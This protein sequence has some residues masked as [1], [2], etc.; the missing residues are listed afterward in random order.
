MWLSWLEFYFSF[1]R[2]FGICDKLIDHCNCFCNCFSLSDRLGWVREQPNNDTKITTTGGLCELLRTPCLSD[3]NNPSVVAQLTF[4]RKRRIGLD[5]TEE[6]KTKSR[7]GRTF[8]SLLFIYILIHTHTHFV[9]KVRTCGLECSL[10]CT[11]VL[12]TCHYG[13]CIRAFRISLA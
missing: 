5:Y 13:K 3:I 1:F 7:K 2:S 8:G 6:N 12:P 10:F 11:Q 4:G 9:P